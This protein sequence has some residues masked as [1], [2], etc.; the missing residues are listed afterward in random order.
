MLSTIRQ[1]NE[2]FFKKFQDVRISVRGN[3]MDVPCRYARMSSGD[4]TEEKEGQSYPC[5]A[6]QDYAPTLKDG[7]Y[8]DMVKY[9]GGVTKDGERTHLYYRP[10]WLDFRYDVGI[11]TKSYHEFIAL[12]DYFSQKYLY[13]SPFI[14]NAREV[15]DEI[16]GDIVPYTVRVSDIPRTDG[17]FE[18]N[19]EFTCSVWLYSRTPEEYDAVE[20]IVVSGSPTEP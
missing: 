15:D 9:A 11:A 12:Q 10:L 17:V 6:I 14:F 2:E 1:V 8:I 18:I 16:V 7:G 20:K 4:Y 13:L 3:V 5:I 19:Y